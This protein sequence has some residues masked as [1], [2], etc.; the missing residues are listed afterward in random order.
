[1]KQARY[2]VKIFVMLNKVLYFLRQCKSV[3]VRHHETTFCRN[4]SLDFEVDYQE[5]PSRD[6]AI[7]SS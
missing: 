4:A 1:M 5:Q 2:S 6:A 3:S 7:G